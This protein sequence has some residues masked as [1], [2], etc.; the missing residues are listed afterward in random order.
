MM[1]TTVRWLAFALALALCA[2]A[3]APAALAADG[4]TASEPV[5]QLKI[6]ARYNDSMQFYDGHVYLLFTSYRDGVTITVD[7]L[8]AGYE[9]NEKY[10][11]DIKN[12]ISFGSNHNK[13]T[14]AADYFRESREMKSV[15]LNRGRARYHRHVPGF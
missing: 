14:T 5:G 15:T 10:Y 7:D 1:K 9:I 13:Q 11:A 12:D 8:Y 2:T 4:N 6:L 3:G